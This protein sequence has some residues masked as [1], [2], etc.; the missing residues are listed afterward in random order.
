[1]SVIL[2][3]TVL[4]YLCIQQSL[5]DDPS[6]GLLAHLSSQPEALCEYLRAALLCGQV[7]VAAW[8]VQLAAQQQQLGMIRLT[9]QS[10]L[11][12]SRWGINI[13]LCLLDRKVCKVVDKQVSI[14]VW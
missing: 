11:T 14:F 6:C 12:T 13:Y 5:G 4:N 8:L 3:L 2:L 10:L 9:L 1:M 7:T